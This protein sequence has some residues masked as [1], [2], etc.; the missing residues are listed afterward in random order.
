M[1]VYKIATPAPNRE[2]HANSEKVRVRAFAH[3]Q[4]RQRP[5]L[6]DKQEGRIRLD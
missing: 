6:D 2:S 3:F 1:T 4:N 5:A